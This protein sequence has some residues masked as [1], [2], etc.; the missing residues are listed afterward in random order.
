MDPLPKG[1]AFGVQVDADTVHKMKV[2]VTVSKDQL[3][4]VPQEFTMRV[5]YPSTG[6][7]AEYRATFNVP[8]KRK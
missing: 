8:E 3:P 1:R 2:F 5:E 7:F 4:S 6:E